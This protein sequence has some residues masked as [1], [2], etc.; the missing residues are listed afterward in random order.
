MSVAATIINLDAHRR[1]TVRVERK[2]RPHRPN[3]TEYR[4]YGS[5]SQDVQDYIASLVAELEQHGINFA[6]T[7]RGPYSIGHGCYVAIGEIIT[8]TETP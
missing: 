2:V 1:P 7:W 3:C 8:I 6:S 4:L 5:R